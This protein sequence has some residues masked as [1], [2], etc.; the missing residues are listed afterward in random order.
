MKYQKQIA[1]LNG[2]LAALNLEYDSYKKQK[3]L[4]V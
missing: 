1:T 3:N 4:E 2:N